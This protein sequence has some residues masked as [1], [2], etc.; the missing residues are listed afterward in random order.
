MVKGQLTH[1]VVIC[2]AGPPGSLAALI[3][4]RAG[5]AVLLLDRA[6]FP[7][8]K[9]CGDTVNP[10][11]VSLLRRHQLGHVLEGAMPVDGMI[12]TGAS[13]LRVVGRYGEG[14]YGCAIMRRD[15]DA[16]LA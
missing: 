4:A 7:R 9:L 15:L 8:D 13:G 1:D 6:R 12:I 14:I 11:A 2:G 3:L 5:A 10:G 16:R